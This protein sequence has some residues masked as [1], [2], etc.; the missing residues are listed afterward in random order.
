[1]SDK[2]VGSNYAPPSIIPSLRNIM[3]LPVERECEWGIYAYVINSDVV[4]EQGNIDDLRAIMFHLGSFNNKK[5]AEKHVKYIIET[6]GHHALFISKYGM[7]VPITSKPNEQ[8]IEHV[9]VDM[10]G[11][12]MDFETKE[13]K[14]QKEAYDKKVKYE[15]ELMKE[16]A[17]EADVNSLEYY[18]RLIYVAVKHH[19]LFTELSNNAKESLDVYEKKRSL[20]KN[21]L[22]THPEYEEQFLPFFKEKLLSRGEEELYIRISNAYLALKDAILS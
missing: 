12:I 18:K 1:M 11:K 4:D 10:K 6:T 19:I 9:T 21:V 17:E 20:I 15:E 22:L 13:Y 3:N 8:T 5:N 16:V 7:P 14:K 2:S